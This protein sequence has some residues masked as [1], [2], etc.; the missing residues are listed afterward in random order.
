MEL[1]DASAG[2]AKGF[3]TLRGKEFRIND[4]AETLNILTSTKAVPHSQNPR[5]ICWNF[6]APN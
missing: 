4:F 6:A 1:S 3:G 2:R 5:A